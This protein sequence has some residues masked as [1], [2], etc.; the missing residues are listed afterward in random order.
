MQEQK[1]ESDSGDYDDVEELDE[2]KGYETE[3]EEGDGG[4]EAEN[5]EATTRVKWFEA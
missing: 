4:E 3:I 1:Q 2:E 5:S